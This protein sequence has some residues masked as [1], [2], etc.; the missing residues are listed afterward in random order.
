L[1]GQTQNIR[2]SGGPEGIILGG[3]WGVEGIPRDLLLAIPFC[4]Q[5]LLQ[6][7]SFQNEFQT[8]ISN[9]TAGSREFFLISN[10]IDFQRYYY[11]VLSFQKTR[12]SL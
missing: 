3:L 2:I 10:L 8:I 12:M 7:K 6:I 9:Q 5:F 1:T 11:S 4:S